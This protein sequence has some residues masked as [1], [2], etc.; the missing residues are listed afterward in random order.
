MNTDVDQNLEATAS[1]REE[2]RIRVDGNP[3]LGTLIYLPGLQG[4]WSL[5]RSFKA[6][7]KDKVRL[8][9]FTYPRTVTWSLDQYAAEI[10]NALFERGITSGWLLGESFGSQ[11][12]WPMARNS[13]D[14]SSRFQVE[15]IILAGGFVKHPNAPGIHLVKQ[16]TGN[17]PRRGYERF[18]KL[19]AGYVKFRHRHAPE[20]LSAMDEF[21]AR[22]TEADRQAMSHRVS[23]IAANDA[24]PLVSNLKVPVYALSGFWD[25]IVPRFVTRCWL[26]RNCPG[27]RG[28]K[29]IFRADHNVLGTQPRQSAHV[30]T[31]WMKASTGQG[32][33]RDR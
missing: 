4:D 11:I 7:I 29:T 23:L 22:R 3:T 14:C 28:A 30:I 13:S 27:Y 12:A 6:A 31:A 20:T 1:I 16:I 32:F 10:E 17:C 5:L 25:P 24:R 33:C 18:L 2:L 26:Q 9:E 19:Y 8:V 21:L 15:G